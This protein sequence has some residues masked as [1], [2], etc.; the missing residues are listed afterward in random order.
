MTADYGS[1]EQYARQ[2]V[3]ERHPNAPQLDAEGIVVAAT[4]W[5]GNTFRVGEQVMYCIGA[6]RGQMMAI[7]EV[8]KIDSERTT[9]GFLRHATPEETPDVI[10]DDER[11]VWDDLPYDDVRVM[12]RTLRTSGRFRE[13]P[14][15]KPAWVN[16]MNITALP[17]VVNS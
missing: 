1:A 6:G 4:D 7:G 9:R 14:R 3:A 5:L 10:R 11:W 15:S 2:W 12:V 17:A 16:P 8:V 13:E